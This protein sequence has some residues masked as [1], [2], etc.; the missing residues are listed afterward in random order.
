[1]QSRCMRS[2]LGVSACSIPQH[3]LCSVSIQT[4]HRSHLC[5]ALVAAVQRLHDCQHPAVGR[6]VLPHAEVVVRM[7]RHLQHITPR[8]CQADN[9]VLLCQFPHA[10]DCS[11][12]GFV[13]H[14]IADRH[15][16]K[17]L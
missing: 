6:H 10:T 13:R 9:A 7:G 1:M 11:E 4:Q 2:L 17:T 8:M 14:H 5:N 3:R 16:D 15:A 12:H